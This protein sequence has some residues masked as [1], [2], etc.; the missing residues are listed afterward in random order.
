MQLGRHLELHLERRLGA[1]AQHE[2]VT[3][4]RA[5]DAGAQVELL[6]AVDRVGERLLEA[7]V[8]EE[9]SAPV[10]V[11]SDELDLSVEVRRADAI[12]PRRSASSTR[13]RAGRRGCPCA[14]AA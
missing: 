3:E 2:L 4:E 12:A 1:V 5:E 14:R 11:S 9:V 6:A 13:R 8:E 7:L 10:V